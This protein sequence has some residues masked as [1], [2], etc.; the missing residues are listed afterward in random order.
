[1]T[2]STRIGLLLESFMGGGIE[3]VTLSLA[4]LLKERGHQVVLLVCRPEG[5][6]RDS[7]GE[8]ISVR[9]LTPGP[10][11]KGR[12]FALK[13]H[14][15]SRLSLIAPVLL[16]RQPSKT[17]RCLPDLIH[18]LDSGAIDALLSP[19]PHLNVEAVWARRLSSVPV[20][21]VICEHIQVS[22]FLSERPVWRNRFLGPL[23]RQAYPDADSIV[24]VS[25]AVADELVSFA[26]LPRDTITTVYN[27][28]VTGELIRQS[29]E[30][31]DHPWF[32]DDDVPVVLTVGRIAE[33]K[34]HPTLIRAFAK[35]RAQRHVRLLILG[36]GGSGRQFDKKRDKKR[37]TLLALAQELGVAEDVCMPGFKSNPLK[38]MANADLFV[39]SSRYEGLPT[40]IIEAL[41]CG[42][43]V[44]STD[45][46]GSVEILDKG[47]YG[48][49]VPVGD[50]DS[51]ASE[52]GE[53]LRVEPDRA[54][55]RQR[56]E[57][58][59]AKRAVLHYE[60]L[61]AK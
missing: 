59:S 46:P 4:R 48:R 50:V 12:V 11:W 23:M 5:P 29:K 14:H 53:A 22:H 8:G 49:I 32:R 30:P 16:P 7:I 13:A 51:L 18:F 37:E 34:D 31:V 47:H 58:F 38:Y 20:R 52:M 28:V 10:I 25:N 40:V 9:P 43:P 54:L 27:P 1:M 36:E 55:L 6:L 3:R 41:A 42:C 61:L 24:A 19:T 44:V 39:L 2:K 57:E 35:L 60:S 17:L 26:R 21:L 45:C 15:E 33:Q 56:A